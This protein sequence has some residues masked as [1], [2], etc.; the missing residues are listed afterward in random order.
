MSY[1]FPRYDE[2][3]M[4]PG[5]FWQRPGLLSLCLLTPTNPWTFSF[6]HLV[7]ALCA[8]GSTP[9]FWGFFLESFYF[10]SLPHSQQEMT[11]KVSFFLLSRGVFSGGSNWRCFP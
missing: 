4:A 8:R 1:H 9:F 3:L 2:R 6:K 10:V 5:Q 7:Q 11:P